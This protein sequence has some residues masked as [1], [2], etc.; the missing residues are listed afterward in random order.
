MELG[1]IKKSK[2]GT[3]PNLI[4]IGAGKC[5][6]TSLHYYLGLHP[7]ISMS[8]EKELHFFVCELN[9]D[10]GI[11]WYKSSFTGERMIY[12]EASP[13]YTNYPFFKGVPERMHSVVPQAKLI[14]IL[15]DP[16]DRIIS[17][18]INDYSE[19]KVDRRI[20][21]VLS[22]LDDNPLVLKSKYFMQLQ[23]YL[24]YF[25]KSNILI[26]TLEDLY[27]YRRQMLQEIFRFLNVDE[28]FYCSK[29][30]DI[31]HKSTSKRRKSRA[32][33]VLK[34]LYEANIAKLF[35]LNVRTN[36]GRFLSV[37]FS[38]KIDRPILDDRLLAQ[39]VD[40]LKEDINCLRGY[41]GRDFKD[42]CV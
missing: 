1:G 19:G 2:K 7:Q 35:S 12:G 11:E 26:I 4:I 22:H 13:S 8:W 38:H 41:T 23:Q 36:I 28:T 9:W 17:H 29:H 24:K 39:L 37:P 15:R 14:Y 30:L 20:E 33:L 32:G 21:D 31:K 25:P 10:K 40:Y 16:I 18:Y 6:T 42:W 3:L 5:G 27:R 34:R